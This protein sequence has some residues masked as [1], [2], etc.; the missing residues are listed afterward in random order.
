MSDKP[1]ADLSF[2]EAMAELEEVVRKIDS[3]DAPL[4]AAI[5]LY[6][7]G[8]ALHRH[9]QAKLAAAE[10]KIAKIAAGPDGKA[11]G[12]DPVDPD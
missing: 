9:C 7:R 8:E 12:L 2:E 5:S 4:E 6:D 3:G 10:E 1:V 11:A